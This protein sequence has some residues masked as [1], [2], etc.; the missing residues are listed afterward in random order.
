[1]SILEIIKRCR[2]ITESKDDKERLV[3]E[4][5]LFIIESCGEFDDVDDDDNTNC[6]YVD[7]DDID[8]EVVEQTVK[9]EV[10]YKKRFN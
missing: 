7:I 10:P 6:S 8:D 2:D 1:M 9:K 5:V 3:E 4:L